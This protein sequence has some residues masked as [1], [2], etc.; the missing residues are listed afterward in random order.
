LTQTQSH[1]NQQTPTPQ[2]PHH[3]LAYSSAPL[4]APQ[5][6]QLPNSNELYGVSYPNND[7]EVHNFGVAVNSTPNTAAISEHQL[8]PESYYKSEPENRRISL[9]QHGAPQQQQEAHH[10]SPTIAPHS[11]M[12][13]QQQQQQQQQQSQQPPHF[14]TL[15]ST[16]LSAGLKRRRADAEDEEL[17]GHGQLGA[18]MGSSQRKRSFTLP[19]GYGT[20]SS[21]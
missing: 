3:S 14:A 9:S 16:P 13:H 5:D 2:S 1:N 12:L 10:F 19:S 6:F 15:A 4:T 8:E 18:D 11:Q 21:H 17:V 7:N 20:T